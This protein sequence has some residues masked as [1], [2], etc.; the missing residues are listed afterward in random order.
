MTSRKRDIDDILDNEGDLKNKREK[1]V[2]SNG[3][4]IHLI[5][6]DNIVELDEDDE[7]VSSR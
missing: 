1:L 4:N 7:E 2:D 3:H 5:S 6:D